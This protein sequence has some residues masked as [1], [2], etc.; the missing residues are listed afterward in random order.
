[1]RNAGRGVGALVTDGWYAVLGNGLGVVDGRFG[2]S[3]TGLASDIHGQGGLPGLIFDGGVAFADGVDYLR[4]NERSLNNLYLAEAEG[5]I[6]DSEL[7]Q[8][9]SDSKEHRIATLRKY[10]PNYNEDKP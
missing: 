8:V 2:D 5:R 10:F 6:L 4:G 7:A 1:M 3:L 9:Q